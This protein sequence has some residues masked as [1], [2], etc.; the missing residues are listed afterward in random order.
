MSHVV[1]KFFETAFTDPNSKNLW[2]YVTE[3]LKDKLGSNKSCYDAGEFPVSIFSAGELAGMTLI[4]G[5]PV[6]V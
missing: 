2:T 3:Y 5:D 1:T 4:V 6:I